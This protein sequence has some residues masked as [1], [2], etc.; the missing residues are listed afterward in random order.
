MESKH[1]AGRE[2]GVSLLELVIASSILAMVIGI[3][4]TVLMTGQTAYNRQSTLADCQARCR[5]FLDRIAED[6]AGANGGTI[7]VLNAHSEI[8]F[9]VPVDWDSDGDVLSPVNGIEYGAISGTVQT[10]GRF[11][12]YRFIQEGPVLSEAADRI[13]YNVDNILANSY[14]RGR[15]DRDLLESSGAAVPG[16]ASTVTTFVLLRQSPLDGD[17]NSDGAQVQLTAGGLTPA[18]PLFVRISGYTIAGGQ[19]VP[20][21][22]IIGGNQVFANVWHGRVG[23]DQK[24]ALANGRTAIRLRNVP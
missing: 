21:E 12:R 6:I 13:D 2:R 23:A 5:L 24:P 11:I 8:R 22:D 3:T 7:S 4:L 10:L 15:I 19:P 1:A 18:D 14:V 16:S 9:Q 17:V 20:V